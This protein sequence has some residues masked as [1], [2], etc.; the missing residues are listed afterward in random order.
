MIIMGK[1][2]RQQRRGRGSPRYRA[3]GHRYLG[4]VSYTYL[5]AGEKSGTVVDIVDAP[6]RFSPVAVVGFSGSRFL[7]LACDGM[8]VGQRISL[9]EPTEGSIVELGRI[10]EGSR[11][12][13]IELHPGDGGKLCRTSGTFG[14]VL[15]KDSGRC[16]VLLPSNE[17]KTLS[18][19]CKAAL[20]SVAASG[21]IEKPF[22]KAGTKFYAMTASNR[23][24]P[25]TRGVAK[26]AVDHPFGGQ[27]KPGKHKTVSR[28]MPP[29]KKVGSVSP[30][31]V[32]KRRRKK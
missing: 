13:D 19:R 28:D 31:R 6:G 29:G 20:G 27:T 11:V 18:S 1:N 12:Y 26:N 3:P 16:V 21:R 8:F 15:S 24:W 10:P 7:H 22:M 32:G 23:Y 2:L 30:K 9:E 14:T 17:K 4:K 25:K 5:P